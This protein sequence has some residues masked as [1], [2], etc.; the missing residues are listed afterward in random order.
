MNSSGFLSNYAYRMP[1]QMSF[2]PVMNSGS[3]LAHSNFRTN[4]SYVTAVGTKLSHKPRIP[5]MPFCNPPGLT[6]Q[7]A[8]NTHKRPISFIRQHA[9]RLRDFDLAPWE[10]QIK[11]RLLVFESSDYTMNS[12]V[13]QTSTNPAHQ[14]P[15]AQTPRPLSASELFA[16]RFPSASSRHKHHEEARTDKTYVKPKYAAHTPNLN[17]CPPKNRKNTAV[18]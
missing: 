2:H 13:K 7:T 12:P 17:E 10:S 8:D 18:H 9:S 4:S 16:V 11:E 3:T 14:Q 1:T 5:L 15:G 6:E